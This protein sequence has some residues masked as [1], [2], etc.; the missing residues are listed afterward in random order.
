MGV[1]AWVCTCLGVCMYVCMCSYVAMCMNACSV[2]Q[3]SY[4]L[5]SYSIPLCSFLVLPNFSNTT[6]QKSEDISCKL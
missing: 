4:C 2:E 6:I 5:C 3:Y 1:C